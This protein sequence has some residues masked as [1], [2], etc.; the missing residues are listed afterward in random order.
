MDN[1]QESGFEVQH[2]NSERTKKVAEMFSWS[3]KVEG[4]G[5]W[6]YQPDSHRVWLAS[7]NNCYCGFVTLDS[8]DKLI[9]IWT[10]LGVRRQEVATEL[11]KYICERFFLM[12]VNFG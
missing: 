4:V 8:S 11:L 3:T 6:S 1:N 7:L 9:Q 2:V 10:D 12:T 5:F